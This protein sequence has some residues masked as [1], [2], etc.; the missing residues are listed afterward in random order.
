MVANFV[1]GGAA[2]DVLARLAWAD[3]LV[4][5]VGVASAQASTH[6]RASI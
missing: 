5:D 3:V 6:G 4:L 2:I 1:A